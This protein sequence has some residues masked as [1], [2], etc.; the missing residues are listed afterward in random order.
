MPLT[1]YFDESGTNPYDPALVI[2]G[3]VSDE[4]RWAAFSEKWA[5]AL[6]E[7]GVPFWHMADFEARREQFSDWPRDDESRRRLGH[8]LGL[9]TN[10]V[11]AAMFVS[12]PKALFHSY[13][14]PTQ[15]KP[16]SRMY[17]M[18]TTYL[19][20]E[21]F[22]FTQQQ[23]LRGPIALV[24]EQGAKG[25][26]EV[27]TSY[28]SVSDDTTRHY[29]FSSLTFAKKQA[30]E[31]LQAADILAYEWFRQSRKGAGLDPR[32]LRYPLRWI[33]ERVPHYGGRVQRENL[34]EMFAIVN[35]EL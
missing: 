27:Q 29:D 28:N 17:V 5:T 32:P 15:P 20:I 30:F 8:L 35:G 25:R 23:N 13:M 19:L 3:F 7:W 2:A 4:E 31:G 33:A 9:I 22:I 14:E 12:L 10:H 26:H 1:A 18:T 24:F 21:T 11:M 34:D 6:S 16:E